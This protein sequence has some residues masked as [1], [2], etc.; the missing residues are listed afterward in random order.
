MSQ[1]FHDFQLRGR[2]EQLDLI[3]ARRNALLRELFYMVQTTRQEMIFVSPGCE[4][5][6]SDLQTFLERFDLSKD[7]NQGSITNFKEDLSLSDRLPPQPSHSAFPSTPSRI[8]SN[9]ATRGQ[10]DIVDLVDLS[11]STPTKSHHNLSSDE[12][13]TRADVPSLP[14]LKDVD[15]SSLLNDNRSAEDSDEDNDELDLIGSSAFSREGERRQAY[16]ATTNTSE[17]DTPLQIPS[18]PVSADIAEE[19]VVGDISMEGPEEPVPESS[20]AEIESEERV[21]KPSIDGL[22]DDDNM[23][24]GPFEES[25]SGHSPK[26]ESMDVDQDVVNGTLQKPVMGDALEVAGAGNIPLP[27]PNEMH[28]ERKELDDSPAVVDS[29]SDKKCSP[30]LLTPRNLP[31]KIDLPPIVQEDILIPAPSNPRGDQVYY[32]DTSAASKSLEAPISPV[33]YRQQYDPQYKIPPL[34]VL[35]AEFSRKTKATKRKKER[36]RDKSDG[37]KD[38]DEVLPMGVSRWGATVLANPVWKKVSRATKCLST[39]EWGVAMTELRLIRT[40]ERIDSLKADGR[41]SFRQPKKQRGIGGLVKTHWDYLMDEMKWMRIDF[42]EERRWKMALAYN[43][44][45]AVLEW[46]A[47]GT[48]EQRLRAGICVKWQPSFFKD[49]PDGASEGMSLNE[50]HQ[51]QLNPSLLG[52]DYG[53]EDDDEDE[54]DK[55]IDALEPATLIKDSLDTANELRPK[56]EEVDDQSALRLIHDTVLDNAEADQLMPAN[57][58][59][60]LGTAENVNAYLRPTSTNPI[61][62]SKSSSQSANGDGDA[63]TAS[64]KL[65]K[66][67]LAPLREQI[68]YCE[69]TQLFTDFDC[70]IDVSTVLQNKDLN[71]HLDLATLFPDLQPLGLLDVH[72]GPGPVPNEGKKRIEKRSDRD[73]PNKRI[74]DTTYTKLYPTGRFMYTKPTLLGPLQPSKRWKTDRWLSTE[75]TSVVPDDGSGRIPDDSSNELFDGRLNP[76]TSNF[77]LQI[78][79]SSKDKDARKRAADHVWSTSDDALLK[80]LVD[81]YTNNWPLIAEC[82]NASR[83]TVPTDRRTPSDC[84]ERWKGRWGSERKPLAIEATQAPVD[85]HSVSG[86][87]GQM[88]TR[89]VKRLAS[90]S[91]SSPVNPGVVHSSESKKRRRHILLQESMRR[92]AK[93]RAEAAQKVLTNQRKTPAIHETH[94][95]YNKLPKLSPMDLSRMKAEKDARDSQDLAMAR[96][97]QGLLMREQAQRVATIPTAP[98]PLQPQQGTSQSQ[99]QPVQQ[100]PPPLTQQQQQQQQQQQHQHSQMSQ[101]HQLQA[102]QQAIQSQRSTGATSTIP[103]RSARLSTAVNARPLSQQG[104]HLQQG[105]GV[106]VPAPL[107]AG[108]QTNLSQ[109]NLLTQSQNNGNVFYGLPPN[110]TQEQLML[111]IQT[112]QQHQQ[113]QQQQPTNQA[114]PNGFI[115]QP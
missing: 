59:D 85:D 62:G 102:Q 25:S 32:I 36:E 73:D 17:Q 80:S 33:H 69:G 92:A 98:A 57:E 115:T 22:D 10:A 16:T 81:K 106:Q 101:L 24:A 18:Y 109:Q 76:T 40:L 15:E 39:R 99:P 26:R 87:S 47:A 68:A 66:S 50:S 65:S 86:S 41:W 84:L 112:A 2:I 12:I 114:S 11:S 9:R 56:D 55:I 54:Q 60:H 78:H 105:R 29:L 90:A 53:S 4:A 83:L 1:T 79:A 88:T 104:Q 94:N 110:L 20:G 13:Q 108:A 19:P 8:E 31:I 70:H 48:P 46:H 95:Q 111:A 37:K 44:S 89:G 93:K 51:E 43:L 5:E 3:V 6:D 35:P 21:K 75:E 103:N 97:R 82:Y 30:E 38:R 72:R 45:T 34:N 42:R 100:V 77:A 27:Q 61:L 96:Q 107:Q 58:G 52:V 14:L 113:H 28:S 74:E 63:Q 67:V 71:V 49:D 64:A 91:I 7:P 23:Q